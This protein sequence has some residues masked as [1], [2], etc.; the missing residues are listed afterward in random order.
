[1]LVILGFSWGKHVKITSKLSRKKR[2]FWSVKKR[3]FFILFLI[4]QKWNFTVWLVIVYPY[5]VPNIFLV[6]YVARLCREKIEITVI[7]D[8]SNLRAM[9]SPTYLFLCCMQ[10]LKHS[11][12]QHVLFVPPW[13]DP[14]GELGAA[15]WLSVCTC[16]TMP[17]TNRE[18]MRT[19]KI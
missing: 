1:M 8:P 4:A 6:I 5:S 12:F 11:G 13:P 3:Y 14:L 15:D 19:R 2:R 7:R 17:P 10:Q 16:M 9:H 18:R